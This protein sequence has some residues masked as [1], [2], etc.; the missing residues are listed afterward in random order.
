MTR[1]N[2]HEDKA[3]W[4]KLVSEWA[5]GEG[6]PIVTLSG[7]PGIGKSHVAVATLIYYLGTGPWGR[8]RWWADNGIG[9]EVRY[10]GMYCTAQELAS[11]FQAGKFKH[12]GRPLL[13]RALREPLVVVDDVAFDRSTED[14]QRGAVASLM[15]SAEQTKAGLILTTNLDLEFFMQ[16]DDRVASRGAAGL[17]VPMTG[18]DLRISS[19][20]GGSR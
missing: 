15:S 1:G 19:V 20:A 10:G 4:P 5:R 18:E 12:G 8:H 16:V 13:A 7:A 3:A 17:L 9:G 2:W 6:G 14:F 11:E